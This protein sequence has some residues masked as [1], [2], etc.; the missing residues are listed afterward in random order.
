MDDKTMGAPTH[1]WSHR[2]IVPSSFMGIGACAHARSRYGCQT[3]P[4][5]PESGTLARRQINN[6]HSTANGELWTTNGEL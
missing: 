1:R 4:N 3:M 6:Q 2:P 5:W